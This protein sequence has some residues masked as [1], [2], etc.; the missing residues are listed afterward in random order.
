MARSGA[1]AVKAALACI[2]RDELVEL[3]RDLI[4]IPSVVRGSTTAPPRGSGPPG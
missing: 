4:R 1:A 2:D 3:T